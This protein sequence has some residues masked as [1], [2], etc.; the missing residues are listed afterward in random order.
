MMASGSSRPAGSKPPSRITDIFYAVGYGG[1][2]IFLVPEMELVVVMTSTL[3][4][5]PRRRNHNGS[6]YSFFSGTILPA[7]RDRIRNRAAA[8]DSAAVGVASHRP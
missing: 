4:D 2:Y 8:A 7:V 1:Q 3:V 6:L 5:R